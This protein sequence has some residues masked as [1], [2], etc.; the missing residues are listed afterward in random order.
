MNEG[1]QF[2]AGVF[3]AS[4]IW[5]VIWSGVESGRETACEE[6]HNVYDCNLKPEPY[7]PASKAVE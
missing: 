2:L 1:V 3:F 6:L 7:E 4:V 5:A